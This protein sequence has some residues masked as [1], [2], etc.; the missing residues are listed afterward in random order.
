MAK[1]T[2]LKT[3]GERLIP[4]DTRTVEEYIQ[5]LRHQFVY[6]HL[7]QQLNGD[8]L[9]LEVGFGEGYGTKMLSKACSKI[10]GID[11]MKDAVDYANKK[12]ADNKCSFKWYEGS[13]IPFD[14]GS[15][16]VL[17]SFQVIEHIHDDGNY[18]S[19]I[20]RVLKDGGKAYF[21]T[22]NRDTRLKP[23]Q[24]PWNRFHIR[25]YSAR[26]LH[27]VTSKSFEKVNVFGVKAIDEIMVLEAN[28]IN[29]GLILGLMLRLGIRKMIPESLDAHIARLI[30]KLKGH[31]KITGSNNGFI[32]RF[33]IDDFWLEKDNV[34]SSLDLFAVCEKHGASM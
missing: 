18:I 25:E 11:V 3:T 4:H 13:I 23:N 16:D 24:K 27:E 7:K 5:V 15:F 29:P 14:S 30:G 31:K 8:E 33:S 17:V 34:P 20:Y 10:I 22:P 21:T 2:N 6:E 9:V 32:D 1:D 12:Y 26:H 28:R 19:E